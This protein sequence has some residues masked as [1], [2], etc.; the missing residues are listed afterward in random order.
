M[1]APEG[2][3][4]R[5]GNEKENAIMS[6]FRS[7]INFAAAAALV[8]AMGLAGTPARAALVGNAAGSPL[9]DIS[10]FALEAVVLADRDANGL[11]SS[12]GGDRPSESD[13]LDGVGVGAVTP[14]NGAGVELAFTLIE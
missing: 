7:S 2:R 12:S 6:S 5:Q 13:L 9:E 1:P 11:A 8:A 4:G 14:P 10:D 3:N